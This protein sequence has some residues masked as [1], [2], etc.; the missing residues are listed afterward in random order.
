MLITC[1]YILISLGFFNTLT[2]IYSPSGD[3]ISNG[4]TVVLVLGAFLWPIMLI[5][6]LTTF[7][8]AGPLLSLFR[9]IRRFE[10]KLNN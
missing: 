1:I 7:I 2:Y 5:G 4:E 3:R 10:S 9:Y 6:A 8:F